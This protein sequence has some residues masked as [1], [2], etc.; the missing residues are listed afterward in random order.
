MVLPNRTAERILMLD[1]KWVNVNAERLL[2]IRVP[3]LKDTEDPVCVKS[4]TD[5]EDENLAYPRKETLD[6]RWA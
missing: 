3:A 4:N 1:P 2:P 6:P 5:N